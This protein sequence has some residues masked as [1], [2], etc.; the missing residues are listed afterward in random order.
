VIDEDGYLYVA[1]HGQRSTARSREV[2]DLIKLDPRRPDDPVVW[3]V[4]V[5]GGSASGGG[6]WSTPALYEGRV[7][8]TT[9]HGQLLVVSQKSGRV[10]YRITLPGPLWMSPVPIDDQLLVGDCNGVLHNYDISS[11]GRKPTEIW[12]VE[13]EGCIEATPAVW[14]G[15]IWLGARGGPMYAIGDP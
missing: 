11:P 14:E 2:G 13:L 1:R 5:E 8:V 4:H 15:M 10:R 6:I 3:S 9:D 12:K 7:Y